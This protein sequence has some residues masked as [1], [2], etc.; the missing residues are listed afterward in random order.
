RARRCQAFGIFPRPSSRPGPRDARGAAM[1][2]PIGVVVPTRNSASLA[3][4]HLETMRPWLDQ[5]EQVV[6]VDS[7]SKDGTVQLLKAGLRHPNLQILEHPP[8][9]YQSWNH[10]IARLKTEYCYISTVGDAITRDG[11]E[12]LAEVIARL[13]CDAVISKPRFID[14]NGAPVRSPRWPIDD[15]TSALRVNEPI[16]LADSALFLFT[17]LNYR[18]A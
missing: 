16:A 3:P 15:V 11:L 12:H 9:L 4:E 7:F 18:D 5:V 13:R 2:L 10:G 6:V 1:R 8:G 14:I 17:L